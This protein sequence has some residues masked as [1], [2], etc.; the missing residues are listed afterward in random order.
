MA[1][2]GQLITEATTILSSDS[3]DLESRFNVL[4]DKVPECQ[5]EQFL[6]GIL[7]KTCISEKELSALCD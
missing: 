5:K 7:E 2:L 1:E 4:L 6:Q 3:N